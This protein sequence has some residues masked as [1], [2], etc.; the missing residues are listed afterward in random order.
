MTIYSDKLSVCWSFWPISDQVKKSIFTDT[1]LCFKRPIFLFLHNFFV[2]YSSTFELLLCYY[3]N[4]HFDGSEVGDVTE[5][6]FLSRVDMTGNSPKFLKFILSP[7]MTNKP[8]TMISFCQ[9]LEH[10]TCSPLRSCKIL[11]FSN[12]AGPFPWPDLICNQYIKRKMNFPH[13]GRIISAC[14]TVQN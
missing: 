12:S 4:L 14:N 13:G 3:Q 9:C 1:S 5:L 10:T 7:V 8:F 11:S 6:K 2:C